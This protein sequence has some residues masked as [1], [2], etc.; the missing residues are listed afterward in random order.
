MAEIRTRPAARK[1]ANRAAGGGR[2]R[3]GVWHRPAVLNL[4]SDALMLI[5][6]AMIGYAA[7]TWLAA[8]PAFQ[9]REVTVLTPP[10]QVSAEQL[11]YAARSAVKGLSGSRASRLASASLMSTLKILKSRAAGGAPWGKRLS[12]ALSAA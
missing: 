6:T 4:V 5:A 12:R 10:A 7:V 1:L 3:V 9:L 2:V 8:R 11:Q